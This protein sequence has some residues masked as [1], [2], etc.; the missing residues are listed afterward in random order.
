MLAGDTNYTP[1][2]LHEMSTDLKEWIDSL[3]ATCKKL[4]MVST[5]LQQ[6]GYW[7]NMYSGFQDLVL[8]CIEVYE[9]A[10]TEIQEVLSEITKEVQTHHIA[11][12]V[13][14]GKTADKLNHQLGQMWHREYPD[15]LMQ[16]GNPEFKKVELLYSEARNMAAE[17]LDLT[18]LATRLQDFVGKKNNYSNSTVGLNEVI[19][20][21][22]NF[23]GLGL[24]IN[25][26]IKKFFKKKIG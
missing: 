9:R 17:M 16:Y 11:R 14:I 12:L 15:K 21:K 10:K 13:A 19:D 8:Y 20:L 25:A 5:G 26:L 23:M 22:P 3:E 24:N 7:E 1:Q 2:T 6:S 4:R 18:N